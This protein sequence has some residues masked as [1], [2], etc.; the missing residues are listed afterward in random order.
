MLKFIETLSSL[1]LSMTELNWTIDTIT[2]SHT[3]CA[4]FCFQVLFGVCARSQTQWIFFVFS[5]Y[6]KL[7][8]T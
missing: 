1:L 5:D 7:Q 3:L 2:S 4:V 8:D 6:L